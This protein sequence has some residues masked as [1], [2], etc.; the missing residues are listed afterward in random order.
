MPGIEN[1]GVFSTVATILDQSL[2]NYQR[3]F[4]YLKVAGNL[5]GTLDG[6][7]VIPR[8]TPYKQ[9]STTPGVA[10]DSLPSHIYDDLI[11]KFDACDKK[12][13]ALREVITRMIPREINHRRCY[14]L[15]SDD[16]SED[17][18]SHENVKCSTKSSLIHSTRSE[19]RSEKQ[20]NI[21]KYFE[22]GSQVQ[23]R[24]VNQ[25]YGLQNNIYGQQNIG[26]IQQ[27]TYVNQPELDF[28][29]HRPL[30]MDLSQTVWIAPEY[31][32]GREFD[33]AQ[34]TQHLIPAQNSVK[35][36]RLVIGGKAGMGKTQLCIAYAKLHC[37]RSDPTYD[38]AILLD[39]SSESKLRESFKKI[40]KRI[41]K[42]IPDSEDAV[43]HTLRWL[44]DTNNRGWLLIF[45]GY[46]D[47]DQFSISQY[48]PGGTHGTILVTTQSPATDHWT[49]EG[50]LRALAARSERGNALEDPTA[51][52]LVKRLGGLPLALATAGVYIKRNK[53][54]FEH[55]L[56]DY[57]DHWIFNTY[58]YIRLPEYGRSL[59][60]AW[61]SA[62]ARL[63]S[64]SLEA[65]KLLGCLAYFD[66]KKIRHELIKPIN[67]E[68]E[69]NW[70]HLM[71][72]SDRRIQHLMEIIAEFCFLDPATTEDSAGSQ[73][74]NMHNCVHAWTLA[75]L[76]REVY[77]EFH[78]YAFDGVA[79]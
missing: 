64:S 25:A 48:C 36:Q 78:W 33:L 24:D 35:Q 46:D 2:Q 51:K 9:K 31:F 75:V 54:T 67:G 37:E 1:A 47:P 73:S 38:S 13:H 60:T 22:S 66:N 55:Y 45:D 26:G 44:S 63:K 40:A 77:P 49:K 4:D 71:K 21:P 16:I 6:S 56:N 61:N 53:C 30:G 15:G 19:R 39:A 79:A 12:S 43:Q 32:Q 68:L 5:W 41:F 28:S 11:K 8:E 17:I 34:L 57:K 72:T 50:S 18:D 14:T 3:A 27:Y 23:V 58:N 7:M 65:A 74:W 10:H 20:M 29:F 42:N 52:E 62:Y 76:N 69:G 59:H 70:Q